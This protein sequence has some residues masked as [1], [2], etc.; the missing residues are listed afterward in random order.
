[1]ESERR[2]GKN[3]L[4]NGKLDNPMT[5]MGC[6]GRVRRRGITQILCADQ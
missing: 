1:M 2:I 5:G 6:R 3:G 4:R